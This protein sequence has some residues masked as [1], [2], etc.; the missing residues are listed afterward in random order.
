MTNSPAGGT[1]HV[2]TPIAVCWTT[3]L[4]R[5]W[6]TPSWKGTILIRSSL[7]NR[8]YGRRTYC[9]ARIAHLQVRLA[10]ATRD[11][12]RNT[13]A[14]ADAAL[15]ELDDVEP[16]VKAEVIAGSLF[17]SKSYIA[18]QAFPN[19][20]SEGVIGIPTGVEIIA[21]VANSGSSLLD[22]NVVSFALY[23][24]IPKGLNA[25]V[26]ASPTSP[27]SHAAQRVRRFH[28]SQIIPALARD[29]AYRPTAT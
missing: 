16:A 14:T 24:N 25:P 18:S 17:G 12:F 6:V 7:R 3:G 11:D 13:M 21:T 22:E 4:A 26:G 19:D 28:V 29:R 15:R 10:V 8:P 23:Y 9:G 2:S 5:A 27:Q 1:G 20:D